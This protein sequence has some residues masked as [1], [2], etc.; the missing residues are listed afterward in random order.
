MEVGGRSYR[1]G[2]RDGDEQALE[3]A[4]HELD[5]RAHA[6]SGLLGALTESRLLL[7]AGLQVAGDLLE[8]RATGVDARSLARL[9][10]LAQCLEALAGR[11]EAVAGLEAGPAQT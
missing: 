4:A 8:G 7:M 5:R 9:A 6:L 2:C 1:L 11:L 3:A 10:N